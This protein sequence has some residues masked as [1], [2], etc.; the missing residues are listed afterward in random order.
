MKFEEFE[1]FYNK[2]QNHAE[3]GRRALD[4]DDPD[5]ALK[6]WQ[7]IF[8]SCFPASK[9]QRAAESLLGKA[10]VPTGLSFPDRPL[11]PRGDGGFG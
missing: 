11:G 7:Q 6:L 10:I 3:I 9:S 1:A 2:A 8:G 4:E 5:E